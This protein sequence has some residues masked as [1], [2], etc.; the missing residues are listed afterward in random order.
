MRDDTIAA[1]LEKIVMAVIAIIILIF[2]FPVALN[3]FSIFGC[4]GC[5]PLTSIF[6][7]LFLPVAAVFIVFYFI[8]KLFAR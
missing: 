7:M 2:F 8:M 3:A 5:D 6:G 4:A 1:G